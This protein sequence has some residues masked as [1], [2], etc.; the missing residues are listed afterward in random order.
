VTV[1]ARRQMAAA[2]LGE[3]SPPPPAMGVL[4]RT[5]MIEIGAGVLLTVI[6]LLS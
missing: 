2:G 5:A 6:G 1:I 3:G 4:R